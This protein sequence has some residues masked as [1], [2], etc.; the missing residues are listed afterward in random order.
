MTRRT[1]YL[2]VS[3]AEFVDVDNDDRLDILVACKWCAP[4]RSLLLFKK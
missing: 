4:D 2:I 3:C 1:R